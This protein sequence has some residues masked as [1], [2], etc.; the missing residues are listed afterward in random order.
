MRHEAPKGKF[1]HFWK[2]EKRRFLGYLGLGRPRKNPKIGLR[3]NKTSAEGFK[4]R[5]QKS[6]GLIFGGVM[7]S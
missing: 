7:R 4:Q 5:T 1:W 6:D 2:V 3:P